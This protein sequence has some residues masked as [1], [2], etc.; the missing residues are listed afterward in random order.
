LRISIF[1]VPGSN[2]K[3]SEERL[4]DAAEAVTDRNGTRPELVVLRALATQSPEKSCGVGGSFLVQIAKTL[5]L[6]GWGTRTRT[7][8]NGVRVRWSTINLFPNRQ[9]GAWLILKAHI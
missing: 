5:I 8:T 1:I 3:N 6:F 9:R 4:I 7:W 2:V